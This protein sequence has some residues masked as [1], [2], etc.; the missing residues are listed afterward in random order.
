MYD[1][2]YGA[3]TGGSGMS[4][5]GTGGRGGGKRNFGEAFADAQEDL[6][7]FAAPREAKLQELDTKFGVGRAAQQLAGV[8]EDARHYNNEALKM[9]V[10]L[11]EALTLGMEKNLLLHD[12]AE[13][14]QRA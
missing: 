2:T 14:K 12:A 4:L 5:S 9:A 10:P 11:S 8:I 6:G 1:H 7:E 3:R 13:A